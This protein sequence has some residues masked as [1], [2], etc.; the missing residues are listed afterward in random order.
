MSQLVSL[1]LQELDSLLAQ[2][3]EL[4][5][6][7]IETG[8][9]AAL[10]LK[11]YWW[12]RKNKVSI[13]RFEEAELSF[14]TLWALRLGLWSGTIELGQKSWPTLK[15][16]RDELERQYLL[17]KSRELFTQ[18]T[19][20]V[21]SKKVT[22]SLIVPHQDRPE[23]LD[24]LLQQIGK[25]EE[26]PDEI[27]VIDD[28]SSAE[29]QIRLDRICRRHS[30]KRTKFM[31]SR[32]VGARKVRNIAAQAATGDF[33]VFLDDDNGLL[34]QSLSWIRTAAAQ[35]GVSILVG[36]YERVVQNTLDP[37]PTGAPSVRRIWLPLGGGA[38]LSGLQNTLGDMNCAFKR[39]DYL[40]MGGLKEDSDLSCEDWELF[41]R[42]R[43]WGFSLAVI[44]EIL[45]IYRD[46]PG[47][48]FKRA[49]RVLSE[50]AAVSS[51][52]SDNENSTLRVEV[53]KRRIE[54]QAAIPPG[55]EE[56]I[57]I[58]KA[59]P[60]SKNGKM[61]MKLP[62]QLGSSVR[63]RILVSA[64]SEASMQISSILDGIPGLRTLAV[65]RGLS[66]IEIPVTLLHQD[67]QVAWDGGPL[68]FSRFDIKREIPPAVR[69]GQGPAVS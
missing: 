11:A 7:V 8:P 69:S 38:E 19:Q 54:E 42:A 18:K 16:F 37:R 10:S 1:S 24:H 49:P 12:L 2:D 33:L 34:P 50:I 65:N 58:S 6:I 4:Q 17:E 46:H 68:V 20:P 36:P 66:V 48:F 56:G 67:L 22:L 51:H 60:I 28:G 41:L 55:Y 5:N 57:E 14:Y 26:G 63:V 45:Q 13:V 53:N 23:A 25:F 39:E 15:S 9:A 21:P 61:S 52:F 30:S 35:H 27:I 43:Y 59:F 3:P 44:P 40:K 32:R 62:D 64:A 29:N 31:K 47:G